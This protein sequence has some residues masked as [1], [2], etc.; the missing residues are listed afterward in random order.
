MSAS[1]LARELEVSPRTVLR[2][3]E[4]LSTSGIPVYAERGRDGGFEL[5][6]GFT[7][8]LTGLT[9]EESKALLAAGSA[10]TSETLGMAPAFA[11][12]MRKVMA[13]MPEA[14]RAAA[15]KVAERILV[16][17]SGWLIDPHRDEYLGLVQEAVFVG[18]RIRMTYAAPDK[19]PSVRVVDPIGLVNASGHW[20]LVALHDGQE[21]T[22]RL[23]RMT[24]VSMLDELANR[25]AD[26]DLRAMW[27]S[28][29]ER[30]R[31]TRDFVTAV[32][33]IRTHRVEAIAGTTIAIVSN[34]DRGDGW[35]VVEAEFGGVAHVANTVWRYG[36]DCEVVAPDEVRQEIRER[37]LRV[38][39]RHG[40]GDGWAG[41]S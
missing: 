10:G 4:A 9:V 34:T 23:S 30:F 1:A 12:A 17:E 32:L 11:S 35:S 20:Y 2:D 40:S 26:I 8:D 18:R 24:D 19:E 29:R 31:A 6:P 22:Y 27:V 16:S 15:S 38:V 3:I 33:R 39:A 5:L 41:L 28:R 36:D 21:R 13:A 7:T 14:H 25:P 37:A